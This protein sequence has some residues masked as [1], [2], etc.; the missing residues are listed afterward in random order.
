MV[1]KKFL[2]RVGCKRVEL[3]VNRHANALLALAHAECSRKLNLVAYA[4]IGDK[5][6]QL[7]NN[8]T[9]AFYVT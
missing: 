6:L 2:Y 1:I 4:V 5:A 8:L 7:L 9:R 3:V